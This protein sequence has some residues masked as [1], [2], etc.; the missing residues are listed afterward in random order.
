MEMRTSLRHALVC[1][2]LLAG[3]SSS[4]AEKALMDGIVARV[5]GRFITMGDILIALQPV[6][7][8]LRTEYEGAEFRKQLKGAYSDMVDTLIEHRLILSAYDR[9]KNKLPGWVVNERVD[10][11][12]HG[13]F[14]GDRGRF[15]AALAKDGLTLEEWRGQVQEH[16]TVTFMRGAS[17]DRNVRVSPANAKRAYR[18]NLDNYRQAG[19]ARIRMIV[20]RKPEDAGAADKARTKIDE[21][22]KL[23]ANGEDFEEL[24]RTRSEGDRASE[25]GDWGWVEPDML[26]AEL[27]GPASRL[28]AG[29]T[30]EVIETPGEFYLL[31]VEERK[32][33]SVRPFGEV[34]P[35]IEMDLRANAMETLYMRWIAALKDKSCVQLAERDLFAP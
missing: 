8:K 2:A 19:K 23:A 16:I 27:A 5:D 31:R 6:Q 30:S 21:L 15:M 35:D 34:R 29:E 18:Q 25:G 14:G 3:V 11:I 24:A 32:T 7:Q 20:V 26:R 9:Q 13:M 12:V 17:V 28:D 1:A 10:K 33:A 4:F 22:A